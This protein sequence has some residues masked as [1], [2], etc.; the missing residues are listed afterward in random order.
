MIK[1]SDYV[2]QRLFY[3]CFYELIIFLKR[4]G[5]NTVRLTHS[6]MEREWNGKHFKKILEVGSDYGQHLGF[7]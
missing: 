4:I 2:S 1:D 3:E 5:A 7:I 6:T